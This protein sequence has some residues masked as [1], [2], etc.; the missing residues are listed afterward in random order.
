MRRSSPKSLLEQ[1]V[2]RA[3][4]V[5]ERDPLVHG[6][7]LDLVEDRRVRR[8]GRVAAV[9]A[10]E[11]DD[12]DGRLLRLHRPDLRRRRLG[13]E[14]RL[15][16]DEERRER[17]ARRVAGREVEGVEVVARRLHLAAVDDPVAE[18]EEDVL[19]L[20]PDLGDQ[21]QPAAGVA[22]GGQ[23]DVDALGRQPRIELRPRQL[24]LAG[25]DRGLEPLAHGVQRHPG[26]AVAH[27][28]QRLL[29]RALA[30]QV[31]DPDG[32]DLGR[33]RGCRSGGKSFAFECGGVHDGRAYQRARPHT[34][35]LHCPTWPST[36]RSRGIYD[37]WSASVVEDIAFYVEEA[38][39]CD[40][41]VVELAVGSGR[42]A[43]PIAQAGRP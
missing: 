13:A 28:A 14:H 43:V 29:D 22:A 21:V 33:R 38:L 7:P 1:E 25:V 24:G 4:E 6:E 39:G 17:R 8:V 20:A 37:P 40:G 18:P 5:G 11:R 3:G 9:G 2:E 12:V 35:A 34:A 10:A 42:I 23:R 36:T 15:V 26:L 30:A 31:L 16:V 19:D 41:P 32:L 27:L